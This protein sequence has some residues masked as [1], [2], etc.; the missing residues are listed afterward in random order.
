M[1]E[2]VF[3]ISDLQRKGKHGQKIRGTASGLDHRMRVWV[4]YSPRCSKEV[5]I[6]VCR[7]KRETFSKQ[8]STVYS[9][10][11]TVLIKG[12]VLTPGGLE[13]R[14]VMA[15]HVATR[16]QALALQDRVVI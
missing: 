15:A 5:G 3:N 2:I 8:R 7:T 16:T 1:K 6:T 11:I 10:L 9:N 12:E 14:K 4:S 13:P